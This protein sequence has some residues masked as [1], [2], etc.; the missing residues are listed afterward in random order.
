MKKLSLTVN[1][2]SRSEFRHECLSRVMTSVES[3]IDL[4]YQHD[5]GTIRCSR[6][7]LEEVG[8]R[9]KDS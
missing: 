5:Q 6:W 7:E 4:V 1:I 2:I 9:L 3:V 8:I